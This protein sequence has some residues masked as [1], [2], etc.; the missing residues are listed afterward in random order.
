MQSFTVL[1]KAESEFPDLVVQSIFVNKSTLVLSE[2]FMLSTTVE[3]Q[4]SGESSP[5]TLRYLK[6]DG[7]AE[8]WKRIP[9]KTISISSI[10]ANSS[11]TKD[12]TF[13]VPNAIGK[14]FYTVCVDSVPGE[15]DPDT[16]CY[17]SWVTITVQQSIVA[18]DV[19][20]DGVVNIQDLVLV[21]LH[22][23]ETGENDADVNEDGIVNIADLLL[24]AKAVGNTAGAPSANPMASDILTAEKIQQWLTEARLLENSSAYQQGILVLGQ[25]LALL[26]P[27]E[28]V[29]LPNYPNPF[30]PETWIPYQLAEAAEVSLTIYAV[31]GTVVRTLV[32]GHQAA[33]NYQNQERAAYWDGKNALGE[34]VAS[35]LYFYTLTA[36]DFTATR[37]MLIRK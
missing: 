30:N 13:T 34:S 22:F 5:T 2:N 28:T 4:G 7:T 9:D 36:G 10:S 29:L 16:N 26:T 24:V 11:S 35:G 19:N 1:V 31:D 21:D 32:L 17:E 37:K 27:E 18:E 6:W 14:H 25:L 23:G 15:T 3:N 8:I 12:V 20:R 33:G